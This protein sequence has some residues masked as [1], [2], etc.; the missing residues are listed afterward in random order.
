MLILKNHSIENYYIIKNYIAGIVLEGWEVKSLKN[1]KAS[2]KNSFIFNIKNEL[3]LKKLFIEKVNIKTNL[4]S[5]RDKK[6]LLKR[7]EIYELISK[8]G[9][10]K[11]IPDY[12]FLKN[13]IIKIKISIALKKNKN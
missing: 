13:N 5:V 12:I 7:V 8:L 10:F 6:L 2:I 11:I 3:F 4:N 9:N 1:K